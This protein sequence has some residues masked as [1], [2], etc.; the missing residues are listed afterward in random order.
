MLQG[1]IGY[2]EVSRIGG[3]LSMQNKTELSIYHD[4]IHRILIRGD[5]KSLL[6]N[7]ITRTM[8]FYIPT[9]NIADCPFCEEKKLLLKS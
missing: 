2:T 3:S 8:P 1:H 9:T 4:E 7:C 5:E 6:I